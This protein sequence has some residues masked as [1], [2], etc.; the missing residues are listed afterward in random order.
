MKRIITLLLALIMTISVCAFAVACEKGEPAESTTTTTTSKTDSGSTTTST[1]VSGD[2]AETT[3]TENGGDVE[4]PNDLA[5]WNGKTKLPGYLDV[6]FGGKTFLI[7]SRADEST[8]GWN[9][10]HEIW[11]ESITNDALNDAVYER[12]NIME[13][14]YD[15]KIL[16]DDGGWENG[17]NADIASGGG[18]YIGGCLAY[19]VHG[20]FANGNFY[21]VLNLDIDFSQSWWDQAFINDLSCDGKLYGLSGD[22]A[23]HAMEATWILFYNKTI[24]ENNFPDEDIYQLVR[25]KKWT[26][27]KLLELC[28]IATKDNNGD[29]EITYSSAANAD[30]IGLITTGHNIRGLYNACGEFYIGKNDSGKMVCTITSRNGSDVI[31]KIRSLTTS[32]AY[33]EIGYT[34]V[35]QAMRDSTALF[36]GQV[37]NTLA[38][39][40]D[41]DDLRIGVVPEPLY[42]E[43]QTSYYHYVNNQ[44]PFYAVPTS[45]ADMDTIADFYTL[46]AAHS[47]KIVRAAYVNTYKYTYASDEESAEMID[48]I[49]NSRTYDPGYHFNF[50]L[51][52]DGVLPSMCGKTGKN[53]FSAAAQRYVSQ[54]EEAIRTYEN[55]IALI[56][57]PV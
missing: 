23:F 52:F 30:T 15:C 3:T 45:Y 12:N 49:L 56:D 10:G 29:Q 40:S 39:L 5:N 55:K 20:V 36:A 31:D 50:S 43:S 24:F 32:S 38:V 14:L 2:G 19:H 27:D 1:T 28:Q 22:F 16:V 25:D 51:G 7:A 54:V 42:D 6:N 17:L 26:V 53:Q 4:D 47:Q 8:G 33:M 18:K 41:V 9:N 34:S 37:M 11:V 57:D 35:N 48:L 44:A 13:T 46:F 21:N